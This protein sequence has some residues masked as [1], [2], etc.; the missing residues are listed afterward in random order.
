KVGLL[1]GLA[2]AAGKLL[3]F[4]KLNAFPPAGAPPGLHEAAE[5]VDCSVFSPAAAGRSVFVQVFRHP[6][7]QLDRA[8]AIAGKIDP[9]SRLRS[10]A[11]LQT[12]VAR[13]QR[14]AIT[15]DCPALFSEAPSR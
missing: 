2:S 5:I 11:T 7:E 8:E 4:L 10:I 15:L 6:P 13:G 9:G 3:A 12:E 14:L 1:D